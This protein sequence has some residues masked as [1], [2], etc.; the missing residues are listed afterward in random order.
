MHNDF[1]VIPQ[2]LSRNGT[3]VNEEKIGL[4]KKRI[5]AHGDTISIAYPKV[6]SI[7]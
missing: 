5:L 6:H 3:F 7:H 1:I 2:D 4:A